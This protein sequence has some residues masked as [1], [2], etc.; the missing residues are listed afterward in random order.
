MCLSR[1]HQ[2]NRT[3]LNRITIE[4]Y[5][6][7]ALALSYSKDKEKIVFMKFGVEVLSV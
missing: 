5:F 7:E 1:S 2:K 3:I 4:I 6:M